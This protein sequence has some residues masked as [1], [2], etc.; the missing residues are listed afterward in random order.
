MIAVGDD[1]GLPEPICHVHHK[2]LVADPVGTVAALYRHFGLTLAPDVAAA[3]ERVR[4]G[5]RT[6]A[7][8]RVPTASRITGST[9]ARSARSS[10][11]TCSGSGSSRRAT[12]TA[13]QRALEAQR[14]IR[15]PIQ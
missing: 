3:I 14:R 5:G 4:R 10:A 12:R 7:M 6:A 15:P 2:E 8:A 11:V 1:A 13:A 9:A